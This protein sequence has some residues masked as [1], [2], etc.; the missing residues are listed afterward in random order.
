M[1][2]TIVV[3][4]DG[5]ETAAKAVDFAVDMAERYGSRLVIASSYSPIPEDR[6]AKEQADAP[7]EV[8]WSIN[9]T[10][11]VDATLREVEEKAQERGIKTVSEARQGDPADV[12]CEIAEQHD[13]DLLV[14]GNKGMHRKILG[15]VPN[16][17]SHKAPCSVVIVKTA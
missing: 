4:T 12:L 9:P 17:V 7:Q 10:E 1:L 6:L 16:S 3:G 14:V 5:T 13:A 8:K 11:D 2:S 15:S